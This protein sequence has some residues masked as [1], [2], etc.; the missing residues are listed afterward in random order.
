MKCFW[1]SLYFLYASLFLFCKVWRSL[2]F[3]VM[4]MSWFFSCRTLWCQ[5]SSSD[6]TCQLSAACD[7]AAAGGFWRDSRRE[8]ERGRRGERVSETS[9]DHQLLPLYGF[10][11]GLSTRLWETHTAFT[12]REI[13]CKRLFPQ[14]PRRAIC[15]FTKRSQYRGTINV[16]VKSV[17][18]LTN[19]N[20]FA[21][22]SLLMCSLLHVM[23]WTVHSREYFVYMQSVKVFPFSSA[24]SF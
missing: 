12:V 20:V 7:P 2:V 21:D 14:S 10:F 13:I 16:I 15:R 19:L 1:T 8:T 11:R 9:S 23:M 24:L 6:P 22:F 3:R 5:G 4:S 18:V 17:K